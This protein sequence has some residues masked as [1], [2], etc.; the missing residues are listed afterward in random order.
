ML[1]RLSTDTG[2]RAT[3]L[4]NDLSLAFA[5]AQRDL[6]CQYA[7]GF[8]LST[9][10]EDLP[11]RI[12]VNVLR[13]GLRALHP[14][15]FAFRSAIARNESTI[16]AAFA[17]PEMFAAPFLRAHLFPLQPNSTKQWD[18]LI[19]VSFPVGFKEAGEQ[20]V[21]DFGAVL[22]RDSQAVYDFHRRVTLISRAAVPEQERRFMF[23][24]PV[25]LAPGTYEL[26]VVM[27][28]ASGSERP[29]A[30]VVAVDVPP[31]VKRGLTV[32]KPILG[33]SRDRNVVV[34]GDDS[35]EG[36]ED[37]S[38]D[39]QA[40]HDIA[41]PKGSFEPMLVQRIEQILDVAARNKVCRAGKSEREAEGEFERALVGDKSVHE[42]PGVPL[43]L[44]RE[45]KAW[46]QNLFEIM[47]ES[48]EPGEYIYKTVV[49]VRKES[50]E[51]SLRF[52]VEEGENDGRETD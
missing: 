50:A 32:V 7:I 40:E 47:P 31:I 10:Q 49:E 11:S 5:K 43:N 41:A 1:A 33:G 19:A 6:G 8:Y 21:I 44:Q 27:S 46:C 48:V 39:R 28:D 52:A 29:G 3:R 12:T 17:A 30:L 37:W 38:S 25:P 45:G 4:T 36:R 26:N 9:A 35:I 22:S 2:G 13:P 16:L 42:L 51:E 15:R 34:R 20:V 24:E 23:L 14:S 18:T